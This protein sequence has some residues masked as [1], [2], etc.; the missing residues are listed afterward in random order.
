[1]ITMA[2]YLSVMICS[3]EL[4]GNHI[5]LLMIDTPRKNLGSSSNSS[6]FRDERIYESIIRYFIQNWGEQSRDEVQLIVVNNGYPSTL[7]QRLL[8]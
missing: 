7:P 8:S 5:G 2:Y 4:S 6:E 3:E 1:M